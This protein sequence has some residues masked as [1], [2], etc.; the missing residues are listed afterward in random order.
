[1]LRLNS[2][3]M[4]MFDNGKPFSMSLNCLTNANGLISDIYIPY[5]V[6]GFDSDNVHTKYNKITFDVTI[7]AG[8]GIVRVYQKDVPTILAQN[9]Q[10]GTHT[11]SFSPN[12]EVV[13]YFSVY[14][15]KGGN[16]IITIS[17]I[18]ME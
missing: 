1:M 8:G 14:C 6:C 9:L 11:I 10:S 13:D 17:N 7:P 3:K 2:K 4:L 12:G 15:N 5:M 18:I 16:Y